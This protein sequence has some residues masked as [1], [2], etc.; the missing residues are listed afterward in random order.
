LDKCNCINVYLDFYSKLANLCCLYVC[1]FEK[2]SNK[3]MYC[4]LS[5]RHLRRILRIVCLYENYWES[6]GKVLGKYWKT[7][8][9]VLEKYLESTGK[10][11]GKWWKSIGKLLEKYWESDWK[12]IGKYWERIA[13][14]VLGKWIFSKNFP[15]ESWRLWHCTFEGCHL[16]NCLW[17]YTLDTILGHYS[18]TPCLTKRISRS[19]IYIY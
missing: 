5:D 16:G 6:I 4:F 17:E 9:K 10:V 7:T 11:M 15:L 3:M 2:E 1:M 13:R 18:G 8:W 12:V 19:W 14:K